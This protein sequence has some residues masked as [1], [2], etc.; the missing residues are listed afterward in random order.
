MFKTA[1]D[2]SEKVEVSPDKGS[3][4]IRSMF[5]AIANRYDITNTV[6]SFGI[7]FYWKYLVTSTLAARP[8]RA[9][10]LCTGTGDLL[11]RLKARHGTAVGGDFCF[12]MLEQGAAKFGTKFPLVQSD[13]L[14]LPFADASFDL[15][16][17]AFGVRNFE[18]LTTGLKEIRRILKPGGQL[19]VLEFG[20]PRGS[21]FGPLYRWYSKNIMPLIGGLL[22]GNMAAYKYLPQ[23]AAHFPCAEAF[24]EVLT[25]CGYRCEAIRPLTFGIAYIYLGIKSE[26]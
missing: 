26:T 8:I 21:I 20:Q 4:T 12:P 16:T 13:A 6:L 14:R 24:G 3:D 2:C 7:H 5:G 25:E 1:I 17:V 18:N 15:V 9:L 10:D 23:T 19:A 22:T 11:P